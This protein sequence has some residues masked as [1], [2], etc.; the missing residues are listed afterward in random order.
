LSCSR[1]QRTDL[2]FD[3]GADATGDIVLPVTG[4]RSRDSQSES[5]ERDDNMF[6]SL[7]L[8]G[9]FLGLGLL[10]CTPLW[11]D[12]AIPC[13]NGDIAGYLCVTPSSVSVL[14][15]TQDISLPFTVT[16]N[17]GNDLILDL[18]AWTVTAAGPDSSDNAFFSELGIAY[19]YLLNG[20]TGTYDWNLQSPGDPTCIPGD[21]DFG[22]NPVS[23][24]L[25]MGIVVP[26]T[27]PPTQTLN[28]G[29]APVIWVTDSNP[30][31]GAT[32]N[33]LSTVT[34]SQYTIGNVTV[35]DAPE[36]SSALMVGVG[37]ALLALLGLFGCAWRGSHPR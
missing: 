23:F 36:P 37:L 11:G 29:N 32:V 31:T 33:G 14:E 17:T 24:Y 18:A 22:L 12:P 16:N 7:V 4:S 10:V 3:R 35:N 8:R 9:T 25:L 15:G 5:L 28:S 27:L 6:K 1:E 30:F 2:G 26:G 19:L 21:C 34:G 20:Q 13:V